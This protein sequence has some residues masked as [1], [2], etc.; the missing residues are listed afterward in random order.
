[1]TDTEKNVSLKVDVTKCNSFE[2]TWK[3][4]YSMLNEHG[5]KKKFHLNIQEQTQ[6]P[7]KLDLIRKY[8][9]KPELIPHSQRSWWL[10]ILS[11]QLSYEIEQKIEE[12]K[13]FIEN[14]KKLLEILEGYLQEETGLNLEQNGNN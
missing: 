5:D 6:P 2:S 8:A 12:K 13:M 7:K 9:G 14:S 11:M 4:L 3:I 1:M 10:T